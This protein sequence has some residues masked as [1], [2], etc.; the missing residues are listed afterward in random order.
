MSGYCDGSLL[1]RDLKNKTKKGGTLFVS[2]L[3][4]KGGWIGV[5]LRRENLPPL[6]RLPSPRREEVDLTDQCFISYFWMYLKMLFVIQCILFWAS[7]TIN[8]CGFNYFTCICS[9]L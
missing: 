1:N 8:I 2:A 9:I 3:K 4:E 5:G 7:L 6:P